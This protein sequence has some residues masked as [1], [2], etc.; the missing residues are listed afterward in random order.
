LLANWSERHLK[1][2]PE[3]VVIPHFIGCPGSPT[4]A[5]AKLI[6]HRILSEINWIFGSKN[7]TPNVSLTT[8]DYDVV[9]EFPTR[10]QKI[11]EEKNKKNRRVVNII[12]IIIIII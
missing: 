9:V 6:L 4:S 8:C 1:H 12:I 11:M 3:D 7:S 10:L 2:H 5:N